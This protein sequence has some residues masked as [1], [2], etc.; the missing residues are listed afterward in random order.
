MLLQASPQGDGLPWLPSSHGYLVCC[1]SAVCS[2]LCR[3]ISPHL[4]CLWSA[5]NNNSSVGSVLPAASRSCAQ[6]C[7][8]RGRWRLVFSSVEEMVSVRSLDSFRFQEVSHL[9]NAESNEETKG[10]TGMNAAHRYLT[11]FNRDVSFFSVCIQTAQRS[12]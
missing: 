8:S 5:V 3:S 4:R 9:T 7:A 11:C 6:T 2:K 10:G 1:F 12:N